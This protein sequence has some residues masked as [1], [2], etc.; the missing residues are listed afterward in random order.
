MSREN[1]EVVRGV[2]ERF[3]AGLDRGDVG[4]A[5]DSGALADDAEWIPPA[6][7]P[8]P[9]SYRGRDGFVEFMRVWTEDFERWSVRLEQLI[10]AGDDRVVA[11]LHQWATG[12]GSGVPVELQY[13][14]VYELEDGRVIRMRN[15]LSL[16]EALEA[17]GLRE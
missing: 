13:A 2:F 11:L 6:E 15:Y 4:A 5:F 12:K 7:I 8:E 9:T 17:V 14:L 16:Q 1:L 10:D 3:Q